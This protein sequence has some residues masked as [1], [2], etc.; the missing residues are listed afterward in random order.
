MKKIKRVYV[1][2]NGTMCTARGKKI[3]H[4]NIAK[5]AKFVHEKRNRCDKGRKYSDEALTYNRDLQE[6]LRNRPFRVGLSG[7]TTQPLTKMLRSAL[8]KYSRAEARSLPCGERQHHL[9]TAAKIDDRARDYAITRA[10]RQG[11]W[12]NKTE[13]ELLARLNRIGSQIKRVVR[14]ACG[15]SRKRGV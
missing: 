5:N 4:Q 10:T 12:P 6:R 8:A 2:P 9:R 11:K 1:G 13:V 14:S 3:R 15:Y 7:A